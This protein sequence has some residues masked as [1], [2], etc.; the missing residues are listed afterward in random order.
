MVLNRDWLCNL[1]EHQ[2]L[3]SIG[4]SINPDGFDL[5]I[6][7]KLKERQAALVKS[8]HYSIQTSSRF[9]GLF[10]R[11]LMV[12]IRQIKYLIRIILNI[13]CS[14]LIFYAFQLNYLPYLH[15][16]ISLLCLAQNGKS[17]LMLNRAKRFKRE[18][19]EL[20]K[21]TE[22]DRRVNE[23]KTLK[24]EVTQLKNKVIQ[25]QAEEAEHDYNRDILNKLFEKN[26][27]DKDG[28]LI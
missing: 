16:L 5:I 11:S 2:F 8:N 27:I 26:I 22:D 17:H 7:K 4:N 25:M 18:E 24:N 20:T 10:S 6:Q 21:K 23:I 14:M 3:I 12:S 1:C 9:A 13:F 15:L 28:N 19:Q